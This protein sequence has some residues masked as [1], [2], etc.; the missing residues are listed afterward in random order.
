MR[1]SFRIVFAGAFALAASAPARAQ[2]PTIT[3][4]PARPSQGQLVT[5]TLRDA[6]VASATL[7]GEP[8]HFGG[9]ASRASALA[10]IPVDAKDSLP[11]RM[12]LASGDSLVRWIRVRPATWPVERLRVAARYGSKPDSALEARTDEE[13]HRALEVSRRSHDTPRLW[14][15]GFVRPRP[16]RVTSG[17]GKGREYNGALTSRHMGT[18]FAGAT[19]TPVKATNRGVVALADTFYYGGRV[20]Y[21]DHGEGLV[22]AYM[23]LS[24]ADVAVG[25][26]VA[27]GQVIG[28][29][30]ATGRVTGPH[31]HWVVRY[32]AITVDPLSL[33][34]LTPAPAPARAR[35]AP[36]RGASKRSP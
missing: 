33:P 12:Q 18:D 24:R 5:I 31:L 22:S 3:V 36:A 2:G 25:D 28:R 11:L 19:G 1:I 8:V 4:S 16:G 15:P 13:M 27:K 34:R 7:A 10:A 35:P 9:T 23:H 21:V 20:I 17:F 32:G 14:T 30:G 29:V 26:T 6:R